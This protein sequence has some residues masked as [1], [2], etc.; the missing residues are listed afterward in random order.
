MG[1]PLTLS[2]TASLQGNEHSQATPTVK[3]ARQAKLE[4]G[5]GSAQDRPRQEAMQFRN[6]A[7]SNRC[8]FEQGS[9]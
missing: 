5:Q 2:F 6:D 4:Q 7:V 1:F 8:C 9:S 3:A